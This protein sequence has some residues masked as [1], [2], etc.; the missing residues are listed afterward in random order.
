VASA[1]VPQEEKIKT[2]GL[3]TSD[4]IAKSRL[5]PVHQRMKNSNSTYRNFKVILIVG[6]PFRVYHFLNLKSW[7]Q[8]KARPYLELRL[9]AA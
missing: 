5:K 4:P 9:S 8:A 2:A 1:D 7:G 6:T 3:E